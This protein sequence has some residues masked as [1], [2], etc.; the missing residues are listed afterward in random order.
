MT[1][2]V[3]C[4]LIKRKANVLFENEKICLML[5]PEPATPGHL[6]ILPKKHFPILEQV[7]DYVIKEMFVNANKASTAL[8]ETLGAQ[9][10]N[11]LIQNGEPAGQKHSHAMLNIIPR[12]ENDN[13]NLSWTPK[14]A[15]DEEMKTLELQLKGKTGA[16]GGFQ[17]EKQKPIEIEGA[18]EIPKEDWRVKELRRIP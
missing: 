17:K 2:C 9:G 5:S 8:F 1:E 6:I 14:Q 13:L 18:K 11:I 12:F 15:N 16:V 7:P 10:T 3:F 4:E